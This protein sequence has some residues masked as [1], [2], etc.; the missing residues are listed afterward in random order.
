MVREIP[1]L[2]GLNELATGEL[3]KLGTQC[4][5]MMGRSRS[6]GISYQRFRRWLTLSEN[7][8]H[9]RDHFNSAVSRKHLHISTQGSL[10]TLE[11]FSGTGTKVNGE[12]LITKQTYDLARMKVTLQLGSADEVFRIELMDEGQADAYLATLPP[13]ADPTRLPGVPD[14]VE[15]ATPKQNRVLPP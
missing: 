8:R 6:C 1:V 12:T 15:E 3:F 11:N 2:R 9:I 13:I 10:L 4:D 7:E 5:V 14:P